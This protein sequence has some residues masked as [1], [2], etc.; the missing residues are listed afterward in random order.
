MA[1]SVEDNPASNSSINYLA[2]VDAGSQVI[3]SLGPSQAIYNT[4]SFV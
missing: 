1:S 3:F 2:I 4:E